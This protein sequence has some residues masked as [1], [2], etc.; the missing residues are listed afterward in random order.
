M[1]AGGSAS[2]AGGRAQ[3]IRLAQVPR[4][5]QGDGSMIGLNACLEEFRQ[6]FAV[7]KAILHGGIVL[8]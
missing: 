8:D 3:S 5:A 4:E 2:S 6:L 7:T 1:P